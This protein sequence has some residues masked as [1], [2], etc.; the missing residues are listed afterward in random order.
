MEL[1]ASTPASVQ[2]NVR[3]DAELKQRG[4]AALQS[5]GFSP[6]KAVRALWSLACGGSQELDELKRMLD[7]GRAADS[8]ADVA[9]DDA[10]LREGWSLYG[11]ALQQ[12]SASGRA[13]PASPGPTDEELLEESLWERLE[14]KGLA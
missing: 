10:A 13:C 14:E 1:A 5:L 12:V 9:V 11:S 7:L 2:M 3:M 6:T 8:R 4:D